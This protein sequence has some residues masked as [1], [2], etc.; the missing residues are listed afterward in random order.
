MAE[1]HP[2]KKKIPTKNSD[3]KKEDNVSSVVEAAK[4]KKPTEQPAPDAIKP[5]Q[6]KIPESRK[7]EFKAYAA[8]RGR[9]MNALF[10]DMFEQY[11][12]HS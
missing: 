6:L 11:K 5:L 1:L 2:P 4:S 8:M 9:S 10:L 12:K 3:K 7:N